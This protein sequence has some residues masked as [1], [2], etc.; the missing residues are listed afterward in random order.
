MIWKSSALIK[1]IW[2]IWKST[3]YK[4][5]WVILGLFPIRLQAKMGENNSIE[6]ITLFKKRFI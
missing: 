3:W 1:T 4:S 2:N 5:V 6:Q